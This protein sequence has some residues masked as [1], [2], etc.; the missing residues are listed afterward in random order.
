MLLQPVFSRRRL[1]MAN[2]I[3]ENHD[4]D[5]ED[6]G[7]SEGGH[8]EGESGQQC[9]FQVDYDDTGAKVG[10]EGGGLEVE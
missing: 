1:E 2:E 8:K 3:D 5:G 4:H 9:R 10:I 6:V 7:G